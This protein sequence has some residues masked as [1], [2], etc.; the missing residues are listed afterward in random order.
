MGNISTQK[1]MHGEQAISVI[2]EHC[3]TNGKHFDYIL[4]DINMPVMD[5][6]TCASELRK[7]EKHGEVSFQK[8]QIIALS[9]TTEDYFKQEGGS[10]YFDSFMTK[11]I[12]REIL[13]KLVK[14]K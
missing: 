4:L 6:F 10:K 7:M 1:A 2:K 13:E 8:T 14:G 3:V 5:G 9:A 11:P 12:D